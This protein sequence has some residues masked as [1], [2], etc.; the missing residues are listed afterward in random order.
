MD[1]HG[2]CRHLT[3]L[4]SAKPLRMLAFR[5]KPRAISDT[6]RRATE[7]HLSR[8]VMSSLDVISAIE[9]ELHSSG[10]IGKV[11]P[12]VPFGSRPVG[13]WIRSVWP[14][15]RRSSP[16]AE[17]YMKQHLFELW[18]MSVAAVV[19]LGSFAPPA[20]SSGGRCAWLDRLLLVRAR[21]P[22]AISTLF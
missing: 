13:R 2:I 20:Q 6:G 12:P 3:A 22:L 17:R 1:Q 16:S 10:W 9:D 11:R 14:P 7:K 5:P 15:H 18:Q 21:P 4:K 8:H 19:P